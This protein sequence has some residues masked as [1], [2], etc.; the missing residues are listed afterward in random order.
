MTL[1]FKTN[2]NCTGCK[3]KVTPFLNQKEEI[4]NW[5]VDLDNPDK[6]LSI[7]AKEL[8]PEAVIEAVGKAGFKA[9]K[10]GG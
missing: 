1:K 2:I 4:I 10:I 9:E 3:A 6:I 5:E 7:D 8:A